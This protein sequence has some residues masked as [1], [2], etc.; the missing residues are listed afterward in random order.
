MLPFDSAKTFVSLSLCD[1]LCVLSALVRCSCSASLTE[2]DCVR[3]K[4]A[5]ERRGSHDDLNLVHVKRI[6]RPQVVHGA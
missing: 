6:G 5:G 4:D 3:V 1:P 2:L